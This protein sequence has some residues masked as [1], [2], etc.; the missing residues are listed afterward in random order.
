VSRRHEPAPLWHD[1]RRHDRGLVDPR[2]RRQGRRDCHP[3]REA[4]RVG[5][6]G[7]PQDRGALL[8]LGR[9]RAVVDVVGGHQA[10]VTVTMLEVAPREE[11]LAEC[12]GI[13]VGSESVRE[14]RPVLPD[15]PQRVAAQG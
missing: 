10:K 12:L 11:P 4:L 15:G 8:L 2:R 7:R 1:E 14:V 9:G 6:V 13:L 3:A 5:R